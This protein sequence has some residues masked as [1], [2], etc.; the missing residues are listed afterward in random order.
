MSWSP[1]DDLPPD[2]SRS[3]DLTDVLEAS[4]PLLGHVHT[5]A[6]RVQA[7]RNREAPLPIAVVGCDFRVGSTVWRNR[8]L[9][10]SEEREQLLHDLRPACGAEGLVVLETCNRVEWLV[11]APQPQWAAEV[12]RAQMVE[13]WRDQA[14]LHRGNGL[15]P[16][17]YL[18]VGRAAVQ[19]ILRVAVG[20]ESFVVG[21]RE[22]AGQL[23][24]AL[25]AARKAGHTSVMHNALQTAVGRTVRKVARLPAWRH[26]A[27]GVHGLAMES[28][29]SF[30]ASQPQPLLR[31]VVGV[32]GMGEIGRKAA[33]L[34]VAHGQCHV[35]C[36]NRTIP[37][38]RPH[39][40]LPLT[41]LPS[42]LPELD[43]VVVA[44]GAREPVLD[45]RLLAKR[46]KP[47]LVIDLGAP[48]Q[49]SG[50]QAIP[51][52]V[53]WQGLDALLSLP[54][55]GPEPAD[56]QQVLDL[57][58]EGVRE[59][60]IECSKRD[61]A[62]LLRATH[63]L[64]DH[65]AYTQLPAVL[66]DELADLDPDRRKRME[67]TLRGLVRGFARDLVQ[68]IEDA[69]ESRTPAPQRPRRGKATS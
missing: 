52:G 24:R 5:E 15:W 65:L 3:A 36:F 47:L 39:D 25:M 9:L 22:I 23:N 38:D 43:A 16:Q 29:R 60:L 61:L 18:Y 44:T 55:L 31:P 51:P 50:I 53:Q 11:V 64:Y 69:A 33:G 45:L 57:V 8:L 66:E 27:R 48:A 4:E 30:A 7:L 35:R 67:A 42:A 56:A 68:H 28:V 58:D 34:L 13:R 1:S 37:T 63:D 62:N 12:V 26:H 17:P 54:V 14:D 19:H 6:A 41:E 20:L 21:E 40:W 46:H 10:S 59:F 32:V 2:H 49:V